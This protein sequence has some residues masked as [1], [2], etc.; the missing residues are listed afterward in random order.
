MSAVVLVGACFALCLLLTP[1]LAILWLLNKW[2]R[3]VNNMV[4][5][6]VEGGDATKV[7]K[8]LEKMVKK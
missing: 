2:S 5:G 3:W 6:N 4:N 7:L 1:F 8:L